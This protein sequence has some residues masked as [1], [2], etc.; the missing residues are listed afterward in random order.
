VLIGVDFMIPARVK[1][2][3]GFVLLVIGILCLLIGIVGLGH[4]GY[5]KWSKS[6]LTASPQRPIAILQ[7]QTPSQQEPLHQKES[8]GPRK[9]QAIQNAYKSTPQPSVQTA[10][11]TP[12]VQ[13]NSAQNGI[14]IG[15]GTVTNPT[16][17]NYAPP[18]RHLTE[19]QI[20]ALNQLA[21]KLP[22]DFSD[23]SKDRLI[24]VSVN[25]SE[26]IKYATEIQ[27]I[28]EAHGK[29]REL[30][31]GI[32]WQGPVPEGIQVLIHST[33]DLTYPT[34]QLIVATLNA[35]GIPVSAFAYVDFVKV[36]QIQ[37]R[38]G[39]HPER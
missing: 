35:S 9:H 11:P 18:N 10:N 26:P 34:A 36:G 39:V 6:S 28:F 16:V 22:Q 12:Q 25:E 15:G 20:T 2:K 24:I 1:K 17:N 4:E 7:A 23:R 13:I 33:D 32:T 5:V 31:Y 29:T 27:K 38:I 3:I 19:N 37:V 8:E 14:A 21:E 30:T